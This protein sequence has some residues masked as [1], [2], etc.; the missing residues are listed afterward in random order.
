MSAGALDT[1]RTSINREAGADTFRPCSSSH[2]ST[3]LVLW[4]VPMRFV[5]ALLLTSGL[6][7]SD[8]PRYRG[9][10]GVGFS[11]DTGLPSEIGPDKN[12]AWKVAT[13]KGHS[14]PVIIRS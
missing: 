10:N 3:E 8:W 7:G 4:S 2:V 6:L 5:I 12:V 1:G 11:T 9:P 14:S 13:P